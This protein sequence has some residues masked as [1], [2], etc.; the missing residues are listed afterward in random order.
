M[1][2]HAAQVLDGSNIIASVGIFKRFC[3]SRG[4]EV[5][6]DG[7]GWW[8]AWIE[9]RA[10]SKAARQFAQ[11]P[12][13]AALRV[14]AAAVQLGALDYPAFQHILQTLFQVS[15]GDENV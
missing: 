14:R 3:F 2:S 9:A 10:L 5:E 15:I 11:S 8:R 7:G 1:R 13:R 12:Q 4:K 6:R